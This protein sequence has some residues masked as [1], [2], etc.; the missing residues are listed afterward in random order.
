MQYKK[1]I[2][3]A[4]L[5]II[6]DRPVSK[7]I[8][9]SLRSLKA[10]NQKRIEL[11]FFEEMVVELNLLVQSLQLS[12]NTMFVFPGNG[13]QKVRSKVDIEEGYI[14]TNV[15]AKRLWYPGTPPVV[16]TGEIL[17]GT[18]LLLNVENVV[19]LDDVISSGATLK[20]LYQRN[21]WKFPKAK[22]MGISLVARPK[23]IKGYTELF[24]IV[25][26]PD[27]SSGKKMPINSLSTLTDIETIAEDYGLRNLVN[28]CVLFRCL[29]LLRSEVYAL[30]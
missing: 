1:C 28:P 21:N 3:D 22:W 27:S 4:G 12:R 15:F 11:L 16:S 7:K 5:I 20:Q 13:G 17:P 9:E 10:K 2:S 30:V 25:S 6:V 18:N 29:D 8:I 14:F 24:S 23:L 19:V 26:V